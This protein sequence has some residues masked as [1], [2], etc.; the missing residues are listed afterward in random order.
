LNAVVG[1]AYARDVDGW[2]SACDD[3]IA[4]FGVESVESDDGVRDGGT[5]ADRGRLGGGVVVVVVDESWTR[6]RDVD[7]GAGIA[8]VAPRETEDAT[9]WTD[10]GSRV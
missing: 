10:G 1:D 9:V 2:S 8:D 4:T 3:A 5:R 7:V 6:V